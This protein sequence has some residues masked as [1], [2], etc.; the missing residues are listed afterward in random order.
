MTHHNSELSKH[1]TCHKTN[2][3][4]NQPVTASTASTDVLVLDDS[5]TG[6]YRAGQGRAGQ[7]RVGLDRAGQGR[8][9]QGKAGHVASVL[10]T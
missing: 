4:I 5:E 6:T 3:H 10:I 9:G 8:T 1:Q 2:S 7:G